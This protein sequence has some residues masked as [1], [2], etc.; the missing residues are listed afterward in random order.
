MKGLKHLGLMGHFPYDLYPEPTDNQQKAL[1]ILERIPSAILELPTGTGKTAVGYTFLKSLEKESDGPLFYTVPNKTLVDQIKQLHP[2]V[3]VMYGRN[4]YPCIYYKDQEV[5]A[6][7]SPCSML[8]CP[9]RVDLETG[10]TEMGG[11][12]PCSYLKAKYEAQQGG[13]VVCTMSFYLFASLLSGKWGTPAGLVIDEAHNIAKILRSSLSYDITDQYLDKAIELLSG[14]GAFNEARIMTDFKK[15]MMRIVK[16][17]PPYKQTLLESH[18]IQDLLKD[19]YN[20]DSSQLQKMIKKAVKSGAIDVDEQRE[21]LKRTEVITRSLAKYLRSLEYSLP[22]R[23]QNP[24]NYTFAYYENGGDEGNKTSYRIVIKA[25]YVAPLIKRILA[26]KT[27][28]YSATI[29]DP[30][31]FGYE[32]GIKLPFYTFPSDF[33]VENTRVLIPTDTPNLAMKSRNR[34][35]LT[36]SLRK[37]AKSCKMLIEAGHRSLVVV[38]SEKERQ[39]FLMLCEEEGVDAMSY[40][41]GVKPRIAAEKFKA[42][43]GDVL[44]GT[45]SNYGEGIDLPKS[46]APVTFYL[47]P[48]Y[49]NPS[50]PATMFEERRYGNARWQIWN[51]R[52]MLEALQ[53]RGRNVRSPEDVGVTIFVSQQ[54]RRFIPAVLPEWLKE[55]YD[56]SKS[57]QECVK[58]ACEILK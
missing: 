21:V 41:N 25:Y 10:E 34:Q 57:L 33:P 42:G 18:E 14:V 43:K 15:K 5:T 17:R 49:A 19:L 53:V 20:I 28:A 3:K 45:I 58:E 1:E 44:V 26:P 52:V 13:I 8:D 4:E 27:L 35:D 47:R 23:N 16:L 40:G 37:I 56:G 22:S 31:V 36:R 24:L 51:W 29:G 12:E 48:G 30:E 11:V 32:T 6:E 38:V 7:G 46:L 55:A 54:F 2:D 9:H 50:E 39:K